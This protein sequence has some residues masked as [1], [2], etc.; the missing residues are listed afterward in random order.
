MVSL[1]LFCH[2]R[3]EAASDNTE[4]KGCGCS[5]KTSLIK[6]VA[7]RLGPWAIVYQPVLDHLIS[8]HSRSKTILKQTPSPHPRSP[9][10]LLLLQ[11]TPNASRCLPPS[12]PPGISPSRQA[13]VPATHWHFSVQASRWPNPM[14]T[15]VLTSVQHTCPS[16]ETHHVL[17]SWTPC[18]PGLPPPGACFSLL[19]WF[20][21]FHLTAKCWN[22]QVT[23]LVLLINTL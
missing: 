7:A 12:H 13:L 10:H 22:D 8:L 16:P 20:F 5:N 2:C 15:S 14:P 23:T 21:L 4:T 17:V 11:E 6:Q 19:C 9:L 1:K 3:V 18:S